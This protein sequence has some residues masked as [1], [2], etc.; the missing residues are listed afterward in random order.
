MKILFV[1][2]A[3]KL[4]SPTAQEVFSRRADL[5][6]RSAG[7]D[8]QAPSYLDEEMIAWADKIYVMEDHHR[9][10]IRK[11]YSKVLARKPVITLGIPDEY[12]FMQ[13]ELIAILKR[14]LP[15]SW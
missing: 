4:R 10:K 11:K 12:E 14:R 5:E 7:L 13:P 2:T 9:D 15:L 3:N 6:V 1:C 8:P